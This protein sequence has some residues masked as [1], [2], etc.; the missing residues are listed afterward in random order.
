METINRVYRS[1]KNHLKQIKSVYY[2]LSLLEALLAFRLV[3]M[4]LGANPGSTFVA[5]IY[6]VSGAFLTPFNGIFRSAVNKGIETKSVMEPTVII[7]V[8]VYA[9]IG[10]GVVRLIEI[11]GTPK[12]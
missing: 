11:N 10:Y 3:F 8:I 9:L 5:L 12:N 2:I 7:A 6:T 1:N 4:I